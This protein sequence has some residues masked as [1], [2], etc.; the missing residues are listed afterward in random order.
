M[1]TRGWAE[2]IGSRRSAGGTDCD[3]EAGKRCVDHRALASRSA[4]TGVG[5]KT[6]YAPNAWNA[7]RSIWI[8]IQAWQSRWQASHARNLQPAPHVIFGA[9]G[10]TNTCDN[11]TAWTFRW[12]CHIFHP[13]R[14]SSTPSSQWTLG[15]WQRESPCRQWRSWSSQWCCPRCNPRAG[16]SWSPSHKSIRKHH[17]CT[18]PKA[19]KS[20][21]ANDLKQNVKQREVKKL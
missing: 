12:P 13:N 14:R 1:K 16:R 20:I 2:D 15:S 6:W 21:N 18:S 4:A 9:G 19:L 7:R 11:S 5:T 10:H 17:L 3:M 8:W